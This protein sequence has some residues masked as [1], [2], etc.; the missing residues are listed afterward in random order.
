MLNNKK[1]L[2]FKAFEKALLV[3]LVFTILFS[4]FGFYSNCNNIS[5]SVLRIHIIANSD[6]QE[7]QNLKLKVRDAI[8]DYTSP[9]FDNIK[10][11]D[12]AEKIATDNLGQIQSIAQT[13]V[14]DNGYEYPVNAELVNMYF[15]TRVYNTVTLPAGYYD[16]IR[17]TI[18]D[19]AGKN[20]WCVMFP[21]MCVSSAC[22]KEELSDVLND[23]E[24]DIVSNPDDY[25]VKFKS[26]EIIENIK[27]HWND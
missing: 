6:S 10:E 18:G 12:D 3:G 7:D 2:Y 15:D 23:D 21:P 19:A 5:N 4:M 11:L 22:E 24:M 13:V 17:I 26:V 1:N 16:A 8:V 14:Y 27:S 9:L 25:T 20:W